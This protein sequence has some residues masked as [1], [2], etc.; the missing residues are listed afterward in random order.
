MADEHLLIQKN[1]RDGRTFTAV[2][3]L[4]F[5]GRQREIARI[6]GG[7]KITGLTLESARE[8]LEMAGFREEM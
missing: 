7:V 4:D 5:E 3:P 6:I 8:M 2:V 1:V